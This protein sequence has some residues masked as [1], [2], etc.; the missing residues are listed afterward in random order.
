MHTYASV[1]RNTAL[2][3]VVPVSEGFEVRGKSIWNLIPLVGRR[4]I[5]SEASYR[6]SRS[7][8]EPQLPGLKNGDNITELF[9]SFCFCAVLKCWAILNSK[10]DKATETLSN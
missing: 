3:V 2:R 1:L 10:P 4:A 6:T 9:G 8:S 5:A 7:L